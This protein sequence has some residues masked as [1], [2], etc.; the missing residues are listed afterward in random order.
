MIV[1]VCSL[2][3]APGVSTLA[4][5]LTACW[6]AAPLTVPVLVEAD[7]SGGDFA[8][9]HN[10]H[11]ERGLLSLAAASRRTAADADGGDNPLLRHA[12]EVSG[13]LHVITAPSAPHAV[14]GAVRLL[15]ERRGCLARGPLTVVDVGRVLPGSAGARLLMQADAV[16]VVLCGDD[17]AQV[18]RVVE[19]AAVFTALEQRGCSVG[20]AVRGRRFSDDEF[21]EATAPPIWARIPDD[22]GGAAVIRGEEVR[23]GSWW[24]RAGAWLRYRRDPET[25]GGHPLMRA[26][27]ALAEHLDDMAPSVVSHPASAAVPS[28][29]HGPDALGAV[30]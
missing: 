12:V 17:V 21:A 30:A 19:C 13:G 29:V 3:G 7:A 26:A 16:V 25:S 20:L 24:G 14:T 4:A 6:P 8:V 5:A 22:P 23:W 18:K 27:R 2:S 9:W 11:A 28:R 1:A 10:T 15:A